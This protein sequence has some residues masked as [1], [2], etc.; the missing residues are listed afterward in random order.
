[1]LLAVWPNEET[2]A[3]I[4][5]R[6]GSIAHV[7]IYPFIQQMPTICP[8]S[9]MFQVLHS[10]GNT[11]PTFTGLEFS[12]RIL[13]KMLRALYSMFEGPLAFYHES[14]RQSMHCLHTVIL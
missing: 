11:V 7:L 4:L 8:L 13:L 5:K 1:M 3:I 2:S 14:I 6:A 9:A 10:E 12:H